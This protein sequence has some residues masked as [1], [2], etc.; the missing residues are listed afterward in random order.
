MQNR[1]SGDVGDFSKFGLLRQ[2]AATGLTVGINWY[3]VSNETHNDD[4]KHIGYLHDN[5][6]NGCDDELRLSLR[7]VVEG[8]RSVFALEKQNLIHGAAYFSEPLLPPSATGFSRH[9]WHMRALESLESANVVLLDPDNGLLTKSTS[10]RA[11]KS[12][13]YVYHNEICDYYT[14]G[15]SV[16]F[17]NHRSRIAEAEYLRRFDWMF[18]DVR[19][20]SAIKLGLKF[21]RGSIRDYLFAV[22]P[23]DH[24]PIMRAVEEILRG[25]WSEH[26]A[27]LDLDL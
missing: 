2:I 27:R 5:R 12:I 16:V 25:P 1:Y 8:K 22:Q 6:F 13:K 7:D 26:F 15:H 23:K 19:L 10:Q 11:I 14:A 21:V 9:E 18:S 17:Y 4:G 3:L 20:K 24:T